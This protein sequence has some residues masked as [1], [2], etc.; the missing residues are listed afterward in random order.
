MHATDV[1]YYGHCTLLDAVHELRDSDWDQPG[2]CGIWSVRDITA[3]L[4]SYELVLCDILASM[5][6]Q[7][8]PT[9][10]LNEFIKLGAQF[11]DTQ[12]GLRR[13][14]SVETTLGEYNAAHDRA[15]E[16]AKAIP[17]PLWAETGTIPWYG[18]EYSLDDL[19]V[20]MYYGHKRE[21]SAQIAFYCD[22][23]RRK[24]APGMVSG[25]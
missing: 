19:V 1:L 2:A 25:V 16:L 10:H 22:R 4:A 18:A 17:A 5:S 20:Y 15:S 13:G 21:H 7:S 6:G 9:P 24:D 14:W 3:H 11:N 23:L 8:E 12:V